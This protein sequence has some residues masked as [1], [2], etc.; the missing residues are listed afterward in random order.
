VPDTSPRLGLNV[1][2]GSTQWNVDENE[3]NWETLD[4]HPGVRVATVPTMPTWGA[5]QTGMFLTQ[6]DTGLTYRWNGSGFERA[7]ALGWRAGGSRTTDLTEEDGNWVTVT[8]AAG[9]AIPTGGRRVEIKAT[10]NWIDGDPAEMSISRDGTQLQG[11]R[12]AGGGGV[13]ITDQP[14]QGSFTYAL[15][16]RTLADSSTVVATATAPATINVS[17]V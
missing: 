15:R 10:W 6:T 4:A 5:A 17:E 14:G 9:V 2:T 1:P 7:F 13:T 12:P 16:F 8:Q 11:W 3:H